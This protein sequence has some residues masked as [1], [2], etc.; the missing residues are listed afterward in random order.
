M[1]CRNNLEHVFPKLLLGILVAFSLSLLHSCHLAS[2][3]AECDSLSRLRCSLTSYVKQFDA[4]IGVAVITAG[5]DS[6]TVNNAVHYP[7][8]SV[9][10]FHQALAVAD[11]M[12]RNQLTLDSQVY[13]L[14]GDLALDTWSPLRDRYP[15]GN[16]F[17][18]IGELMTYTLQQ[19]DNLACDILFA[20]YVSPSSVDSF[21]KSCGVDSV[22]ILYS[23]AQMY[24]DNTFSY[25]NWCSPYS[26]ALLLDRFVD[27]GIV[28]EPYAGYIREQML[29]C[30]TGKLRLPA[31]FSGSRYRLGHKTGS[32]YVL[33]NRLVATNDIGFVL[34]PD[35]KKCYTIAVFVKDSALPEEETE[36]I[37]GNIS[38]I[39]KDALLPG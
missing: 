28:S 5:G 11:Y 4:T 9:F 18:S 20:R 39:V 23:E 7:M 32:G 1:H 34:S 29:R 10:K 12:Q 33:D 16:V 21:V 24:K 17:L 25:A 36:K 13:V 37:I 8:M 19:S 35:G 31:A 27:G 15:E 3:E 30:A 38:R 22:S 26:A 14:P 2:K 6:L